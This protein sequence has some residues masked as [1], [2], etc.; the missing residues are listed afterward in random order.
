[1]KK[2]LLIALIL[3]LTGCSLIGIEKSFY[4]RDVGTPPQ[5]KTMSFESKEAL[6]TGATLQNVTAAKVFYK[7]AAPES[8]EAKILYD[9]SYRFLGLAGVNMQFDPAD[10][11]SVKKV[12]E[13]ADKALEEKDSII[14]QLQEDVKKFNQ[15]LAT[16]EKAIKDKG[17]ELEQQ[18]GKWRTHLGNLWF[19]IWFVVVA[20]IVVVIGLGVLQ[21]Y[22]GIPWLTGLF[23]GIGKMFKVGRQ[24]IE[25][26]Q[27]IKDELK[28]RI[29][30]AETEKEKEAYKGV[31]TLISQKLSEKQDEEV[32]AWV[33][34][35]KEKLGL[36]DK[37]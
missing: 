1:M 21:V 15:E 14:H 4:K 7:G 3:C 37:K 26:V 33:S 18:N 11:E 32:K 30:D 28:N 35:Q 31:L 8:K 13:K 29:S 36:G 9:M 16:R 20:C 10:P 24:T 25:G 5:E 34:K 17:E 23:G 22:T 19:W 6:A 2:F 27:R 12:F